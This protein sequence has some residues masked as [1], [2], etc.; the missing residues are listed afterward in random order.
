M[1][2]C[3]PII[4]S[5]ISVITSKNVHTMHTIKLKF[6]SIKL[7]YIRLPLKIKFVSI[8]S[9]EQILVSI[10]EVGFGAMFRKV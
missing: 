8:Y 5:L 10:L 1:I 7:C 4:S 9:G 2:Y 6:V 3:I